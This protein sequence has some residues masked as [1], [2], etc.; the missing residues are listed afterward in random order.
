MFCK[1]HL[2]TIFSVLLFLALATVVQAGTYNK[3]YT[4]EGYVDSISLTTG[5]IVVD[6][7]GFKL[8]TNYKVLNTKGKSVSAF[9]VRKG[10]YVRITIDADGRVSKI[11]VLK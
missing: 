4:E 11:L 5:D 2:R 8:A 3:T 10:R 1:I 7:S 9:D 6:D